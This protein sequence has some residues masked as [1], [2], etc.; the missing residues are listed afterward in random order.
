[1]AKSPS[2]I[3]K[4]TKATDKDDDKDTKKTG[5]NAMLDW[6]AKKKS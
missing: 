1:V 3:L 6:I 5:K 2:E 4:K